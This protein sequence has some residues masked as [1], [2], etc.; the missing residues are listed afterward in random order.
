MTVFGLKLSCSEMS[1]TFWPLV[2]INMICN[3]RSER[4]AKGFSEAGEN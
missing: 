3:S 1:V 2:I 4:S